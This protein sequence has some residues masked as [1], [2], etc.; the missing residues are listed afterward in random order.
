MGRGRNTDSTGKPYDPQTI[1]DVWNKGLPIQ[2]FP[3]SEWRRDAC[4]WVIRRSAYADTGSPHGWEIDHY[5]P[6]ARGGRDELVNLRPLHWRMNYEKGDSFPWT[7][8]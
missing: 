8:P 5:K 1:S 4:G 3:E 7:C 2:G 6:V